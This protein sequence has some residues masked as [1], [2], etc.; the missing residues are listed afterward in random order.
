MRDILKDW[1]RWS[2]AERLAAILLAGILM[3]GV[4]ATIVMD[5][6]ATVPGH[7]RSLRSF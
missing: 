1:R 5:L 4:P 2:R 6:S 7:G 3:I